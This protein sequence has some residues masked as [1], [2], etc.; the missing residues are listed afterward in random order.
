MKI[1]G[2]ESSSLVAS[3]AIVTDQVLTAEYT[4]NFKKTHSQ[5]LLPM[6]D[7]IVKMT[8]EDLETIDAIAVSGGPG[9][10]TGLRIGSATGK[11][12]GLAL[13]KP[14]ISVPTVDAMAYNLYGSAYLVCPIMDA[15]RNQVYTGIYDNS[16]GFSVVK[17]QC[18]MDIMDL[19][20]ELNETG[21]KVIFLG[22]GVPVYQSRIEENMKVPFA[23]A[24]AHLNRQ[25]AAAV[26]ALGSLYYEEGK[27]VS[28]ADHGPDY[29]RKPQAEREREENALKGETH[30][31]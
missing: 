10:F 24:P 6:L 8:E 17:E 2:I 30:G 19:I 3:V 12:L 4:V 29:L 21:Q 25:R 16:A 7:E 23:F 26:A 11:G 14:M 31:S 20:E 15:R 9:S 28:A 13:H 27:T 22:D 1:L 5:T 18:A